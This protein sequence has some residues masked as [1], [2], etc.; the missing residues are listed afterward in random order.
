MK[1]AP[2]STWV[3]IAAGTIALAA[4]SAWAATAVGPYYATP[5]WDQTFPASTRFIILTNFN[6][7]AVLDRETGLVWQRSPVSATRVNFN[8]AIT[9]CANA[10]TGGRSGWRVPQ[11]SEFQ[12]LVD[13][14]ATSQPTFPA[15][16]PFISFPTGFANLFWT[17]TPEPGQFGRHYCAGYGRRSTDGSTTTLFGDCIDDQVGAFAVCVRAPGPTLF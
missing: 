5:S 8:I 11:L 13:A 3:F 14:T 9:S 4:G 7:E 17:T 12:T 6:S 10:N 1:H 2:S 15:G 16:H